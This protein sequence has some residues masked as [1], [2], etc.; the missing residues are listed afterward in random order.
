MSSKKVKGN[1]ITTINPRLVAIYEL[2]RK[3]K[4]SDKKA[5]ELAIELFK[6]LPAESQVPSKHEVEEFVRRRG[7]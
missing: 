6:K 5:H 7:T 4:V 2:L 1:T 3:F